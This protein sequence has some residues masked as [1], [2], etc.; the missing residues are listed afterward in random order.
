MT[1]YVIIH[2]EHTVHSGTF[3]ILV[4]F[5]ESIVTV[6]LYLD[7]N[8][9]EDIEVQEYEIGR[10]ELRIDEVANILTKKSG[11]QCTEED[12]LCS[13]FSDDGK[14]CMV[15]SLNKENE[16]DE[17]VIISDYIHDYL[18]SAIS[19]QAMSLLLNEDIRN[20]LLARMQKLMMGYIV[21]LISLD[22]T[23]GENNVLKQLNIHNDT[24][25]EDMYTIIDRVKLFRRIQN[26]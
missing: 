12:Y 14:E 4:G 22:V 25:E 6:K 24:E 8:S 17:T 11:I 18:T 26:R 23:G 9:D 1:Y 16:F 19:I 2:K 3:S 5:T 10:F 20:E 21:P 15:W 7:N 13:Y